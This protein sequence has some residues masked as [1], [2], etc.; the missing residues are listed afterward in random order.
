MLALVAAAG[1][2]GGLE[3]REVAE[4]VVSPDEAL[5]AV[6]AVSVNRGDVKGI[7]AAADGTR[8]GWDLAGTVLTAASDGTGPREGARVVGL[9][10]SGA[11]AQRV[12][13]P[14]HFLAPIPDSLPTTAA[15][16]L[17]VAGLTALHTLYIG[18][19]TESKRVL[20]TGAAG[21]VGRFAVQIAAHNGADVTAVVG[22]ESRAT[23][24]LELGARHISI[25]MPT[26]GEYDIILESVGGES[27]ACALRTVA[28]G[29]CIVS[30]GY[31][32]GE[33]TTFDAPTFYR[34]HGTRL[35]GFVLVGELQRTGSAVHD[36]VNLAD[37]LATGRLDAQIELDL[38]WREAARAFDALLG[39]RLAGKAVLRV[40]Q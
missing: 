31:S 16:T 30:F 8:V 26:D 22:S 15:A 1:K 25:G 37:Q 19:I 6:E 28:A 9:V 39:R 13:V 34:R 10:A 29:G 36:L 11:W 18:G 35:C 17:P 32:S 2:P 38:D 40:E 3:L 27:L 21:G 5:V 12:A 14:T 7:A 24:L 20:V 23:G 33:P 4:P